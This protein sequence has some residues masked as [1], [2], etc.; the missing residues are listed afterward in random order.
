MT[1]RTFDTIRLRLVP[2]VFRRPQRSPVGAVPGEIT[3]EHG[4]TVSV[5][6]SQYGK[7]TMQII[8]SNCSEDDVEVIASFTPDELAALVDLLT[9][10]GARS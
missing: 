10:V 5:Y 2:R 9:A 7:A 4:D 6:V 8:G 3:T 1:A